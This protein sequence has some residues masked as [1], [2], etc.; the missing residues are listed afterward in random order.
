MEIIKKNFIVSILIDTYN[1]SKFIEKAIE[2]AINQNFPSKD[3]EI[4][5]IDDGSKDDTYE[6][7]KKYK[8]KIKYIYKEN[9]GQAS[10]FNLGFEI[11]NGEYIVLLDG[12]DYM[13]EDRVLKVVEEFEKYKEVACVLN[14]REIIDEV[15]GKR[16][17]ENF[18]EFHNLSLNKENLN[19]FI[20][21]SYGTSRTSLRKSILKNILPIPENLIIGADLYLNLSIIWFGNLSCLN[22]RLTFYRIHGENLFCLVDSKKL[23][24]QIKTMKTAIEEVKKISKK[25][26]I[27]DKE[28]LNEILKPYEIEIREK[29]FNLNVYKNKGKRKDLFLIEC[30]KF[31]FYKRE[32]NFLYKIYKFIRL[33][34]LLAFPPKFFLKLKNFYH[35]KKLYNIRKILFP[36]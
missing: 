14:T 7:V 9:K 25:S 31:K 15:N 11:A 4:I 18:P 28:I 20:K 36:D 29:E 17:I 8:D 24:L 26:K 23:P 12:D 3:M 32:W 16:I 21:S 1:H 2:S 19:L 34:F 5:V 27:Y 6:I 33:P 30:E 22:E 35:N 13:R 10:A